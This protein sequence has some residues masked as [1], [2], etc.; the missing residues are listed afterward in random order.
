MILDCDLS[1]IEWRMAAFLSQDPI[2]CQEVRD[3]VDQ[4]AATCTNLMELELTKANRQDAKIFNFRAIYC[5]P[6]SGA[7]AYYMDPKMPSFSQ[8]KWDG[9][10]ESFFEKYAGLQRWH[11]AIEKEVRKT[12]QLTGPTGQQ[13]VFKKEKKKQGYY[14]YSKEKIYNYP[15]QG[16]SGALIKLAL[17]TIR[18]RA[19]HLKNKKFIMTVHD[20]LIWDVHESEVE[21]L[22]KLN[23]E[24][25]Q[26]LPDLCK[27]HFGFHINLPIIGEATYGPTWGEQTGEITL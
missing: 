7:Y 11:D 8:K 9:I 22:G 26:E 14:D 13:W 3:G 25:F 24:V 5:N 6:K 21:E 18:N 23:L 4:H 15:V 27:K 19:K 12:G 1:Q 10:V 16:T 2:M 20:S 17:V